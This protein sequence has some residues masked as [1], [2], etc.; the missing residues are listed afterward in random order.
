M[1][2]ACHESTFK[3][4]RGR[5]AAGLGQSTC[6]FRSNRVTARSVAARAARHA[7]SSSSRTVRNSTRTSRLRSIVSF[8]YRPCVGL[9]PAFPPCM[10]QRS[11]P[12]SA[13]PRQ[14]LPVVRAWAPHLGAACRRLALR[15]SR[16][17]PPALGPP[18]TDVANDRLAALCDRHMSVLP[19]VILLPI[20]S[21]RM[22]LVRSLTRR[23]TAS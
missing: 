6:V 5:Y 16:F 14:G 21:P 1:A 4:K 10:R 18:G 8:V 20:A 2:P 13:G 17:A 19:H 11:F 7:E 9:R 15:I 3:T 22:L 23:W 12:R